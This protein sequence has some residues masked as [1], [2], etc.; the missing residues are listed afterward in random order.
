MNERQQTALSGMSDCLSDELNRRFGGRPAQSIA[1]A[2]RVNRPRVAAGLSAQATTRLGTPSSRQRSP[3]PSRAP[4]S[5]RLGLSS[6][7]QQPPSSRSSA[8]TITVRSSRLLQHHRHSSTVSPA[9]HCFSPCPL[10]AL[11]KLPQRMQA[12]RSSAVSPVVVATPPQ[13][14]SRSVG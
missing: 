3:A 12:R 1:A 6:S 2:W 5:L 9:P 4:F 10:T 7:Q 11:G 14:F 13:S 8:V